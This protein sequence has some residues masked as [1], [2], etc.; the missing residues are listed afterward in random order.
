M[1]AGENVTEAQKTVTCE[2]DTGR[3]TLAR[4]RPLRGNVT[5][6]RVT[7][8]RDVTQSK[9][10]S[11]SPA[12]RRSHHHHAGTVEHRVPNNWAYIGA[13]NVIAE[14]EEGGK[15]DPAKL[16]LARQLLATRP[17]ENQKGGL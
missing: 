1:S 16:D 3:D 2:R 13:V 12:F 14:H 8:Q 10:D 15:V 11:D 4:A 9:R 7:T 17:P 5:V 6:S